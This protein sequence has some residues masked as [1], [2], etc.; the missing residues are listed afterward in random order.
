ME[1]LLTW[2]Q[3]RRQA[4]PVVLGPGCFPRMCLHRLII[5]H[6]LQLND[7]S[8]KGLSGGLVRGTRVLNNLYVEHVFRRNM[9]NTHSYLIWHRTRTLS[10]L[11]RTGV[12]EWKKKVRNRKVKV[13]SPWIT[14]SCVSTAFY[15]S[16]YF[17]LKPINSHIQISILYFKPPF[18]LWSDIAALQT[19]Y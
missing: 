1:L 17:P 3:E 18:N 14:L 8:D 10:S 5:T 13:F 11:R 6:A 2:Q 16:L 4:C 9:R 12:R 7:P 15:V 19:H